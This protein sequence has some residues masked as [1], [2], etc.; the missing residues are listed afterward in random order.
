MI[1]I[2]GATGQLG[3]LVVEQLLARV[4]ADQVSV[5]V[6]DP[7]KA[8]ALQERGVRVRRGD[9][10]DPD[11]LASAF[12]GA[13]TVLL[14]SAGSTGPGAVTQ[15]GTAVQAAVTAGAERVVYTSHMGADPT[16]PFPPMP[17]HAATEEVLRGCGV[18][19]TSL[20]NG[21]YASFAAQ[22]LARSGAAQTG[23]LRLPE[24]GPVAWTTHADLAE[25]AAIALTTDDLDGITPP[26]VAT[27]SVD[28]TGVAALAAELTGRPVHRV[29]VADEE[30][31][32]DLLT[33]LPQPA[34]DMLMGVFLAA[35]SGAFA[36][37]D[38]TL[39]R[40][41]GRPPA[42]LRDTLQLAAAPAR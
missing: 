13:S 41:L 11:S 32:D 27:R 9:Y 24:D 5:S 34:V 1:V 30:Y 26:L 38:P 23:E 28:M 10:T 4:P 15:H 2:T 29:V 35:R 8:R 33:R 36:A 6:R 37:T 19:F 31:R 7:D 22:L 42:E 16:S 17:D 18:P 25:A 40:L 14:V 3:T 12:E 20:R 21:F 39:G